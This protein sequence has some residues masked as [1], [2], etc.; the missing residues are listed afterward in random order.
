MDWSSLH[1]GAWWPAWLAVA[2]T[3]L[4][5]GMWLR[6]RGTSFPSL[7]LARRRR[8][9]DGMLDRLPLLLGGAIAILLVL[10]M[11][12]VSVSRVIEDEKRARDFLVVIDTSRSMRENTA[13]LREEFPPKYERRA[14]LFAGTAEDPARIP[15]LARY[16]IARES[17]LYFL[18][19][20]REEDRVGLIYFNSLVYL[21]SGFTSNFDFIEQQLAGMDPYVTYGT[22]IR[23]ALEQGLDMIERYP[24]NNRRAI[25]LLTDAESRNTDFL[26]QQMDRLRRLGVTFYLLWI[27]TDAEGGSPLATEFLKAA[28]TLGSVYTVDDLREGYLEEALREIAELENYS[29]KEVRHERVDLSRHGLAAARYLAL[30]WVLLVGTLYAPL[31]RVAYASGRQR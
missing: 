11:M 6:R 17:L 5:A 18:S 12:N 2:G 28:R 3:L 19:T 21:M 13:V 30:A 26:E 1:V 31:R 25:I 10:S 8:G 7:D 29:Y 27:T 15:H 16:E 4:L 22:N 20:R 9:L 23:W 24:G 14:G